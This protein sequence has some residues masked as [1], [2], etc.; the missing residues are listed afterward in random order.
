MS[1]QFAS[2][3]GIPMH[4]DLQGEGPGLVL[5][6]AGIAHLGM[7]DQQMDAFSEHFKVLRYDI[8][9]W[10][11]TSDPAGDYTEHGDLRA[12]MQHLAMQKAHVLGISNGG[13]IAIDFAIAFPDMLEKLVLVGPALGGFDYPENKFESE[14]ESKHAQA[15]EIG[16]LALA[17]EY[18]A[19]L[20]LDGPNRQPQDI[21]AE[22]RNKALA[23]ILETLE[24]PEGQGQGTMLLPKAAG[25]LDEIQAAC[26]V[27]FGEED[28]DSLRA[29]VEKLISDV[30]DIRRVDLPGAAHLPNMEKAAAFNKIVLDFLLE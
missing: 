10:G 4:Y 20:W 8:R 6:H 18:E 28:V 3:N 24:I 19:R 22:F 7:W 2:V 9:G 15:M 14:L 25:R 26:L 5:L 21:D 30:K 29:V 11:K 27:I 12:L 23:L 17:A 16:N 13:R 1:Y